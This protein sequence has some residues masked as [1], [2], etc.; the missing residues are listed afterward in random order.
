MS[1]HEILSPSL[2]RTCRVLANKNRISLLEILLNSKA[3]SVTEIT[4]FTDR[5]LTEVSRDLRALNARGILSA[6]KKS[7]QVFYKIEPNPALP[8]AKSSRKE[9]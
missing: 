5:E 1:E 3:L 2:W 6:T 8:A 7:T 9:S 4:A